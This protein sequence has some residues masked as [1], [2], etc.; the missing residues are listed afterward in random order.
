MLIFDTSSQTF[1]LNYTLRFW[2]TMVLYDQTTIVMIG[3]S[4]K[5]GLKYDCLWI[6][7]SHGMTPQ[8]FNLTEPRLVPTCLVIDNQR[9]F[10]TGGFRDWS[11]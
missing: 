2:A 4:G 6:M 5:I 8:T 9:I 11:K 7:T 3:G 10:V 1:T